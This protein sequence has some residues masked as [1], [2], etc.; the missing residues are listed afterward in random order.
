ME[1]LRHPTSLWYI[2]MK[3][4]GITL[5][6]RAACHAFDCWRSERY[7]GVKKWIILFLSAYPE[8]HS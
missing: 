6:V 8:S 4:S 1:K 3:Y 5:N 7:L 2:R